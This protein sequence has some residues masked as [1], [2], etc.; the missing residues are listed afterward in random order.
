MTAIAIFGVASSFG[1]PSNTLLSR[2]NSS[3]GAGQCAHICACLYIAGIKETRARNIVSLFDWLSLLTELRLRTK[4]GFR[5]P[6]R[7]RLIRF[8]KN[9]FKSFQYKKF[10]L[11]IGLRTL[12]RLCRSPA[13]PESL[14]LPT[15]RIQNWRQKSPGHRERHLAAWK[16]SYE[17]KILFNIGFISNEEPNKLN[18]IF[19]LIE[20]ILIG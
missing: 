1:V 10:Y 12:T 2:D 7:L 16:S 15:P 5:L 4:L 6:Q 19:A 3:P 13:R 20:K 8:L 18:R 17:Q 9:A 11:K 14:E